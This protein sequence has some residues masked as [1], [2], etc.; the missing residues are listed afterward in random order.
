MPDRS[1]LPTAAAAATPA[2]GRAAADNFV[3]EALRL[4]GIDV[5]DADLAL[6]AAELERALE[7]VAPL[8]GFPLPDGLDQAGVYRP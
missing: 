3:R 5:S 8:L 7:I 6:A 1:T 2:P 4:N